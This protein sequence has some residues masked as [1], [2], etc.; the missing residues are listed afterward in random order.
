MSSRKKGQRGERYNRKILEQAG[1]FV[2]SPN[3]SRY[4]NK[5]F[6]NLFDLMAVRPDKKVLFTQVKSNGASGIVNFAEEVREHFP[7]DHVRVEYWVRY[8][9]EGWR[10][11][12]I[13]EDDRI[14]IVDERGNS[15]YNIGEL[16]YL[17]K[18]D[19]S[20]LSNFESPS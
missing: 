4:G 7:L 10:I 17:E 20:D 19:D 9:R 3:H 2:E 15:E 14:D 12:H 16:A 1:Y 11:I 18:S 5:D 13:T 8:D 6:F